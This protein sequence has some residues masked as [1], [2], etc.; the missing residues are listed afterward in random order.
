[1]AEPI[2]V[3]LPVGLDPFHAPDAELAALV[4]EQAAAQINA[5]LEAEAAGLGYEPAGADPEAVDYDT[6]PPADQPTAKL[7]PAGAARDLPIF[8]FAPEETPDADR[9]QG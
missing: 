2:T 1:M 4:R 6:L 7:V 5:A 3:M 8:Q 9:P